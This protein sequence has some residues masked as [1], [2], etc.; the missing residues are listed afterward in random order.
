[1][2][3]ELV[4]MIDAKIASGTLAT[5]ATA[6]TGWLD[7]AAPIVTMVVTIVVGTLTAWYTWERAIKL[8]RERENE[9]K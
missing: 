9:D 5:V 6:T 7:I 4:H 8:K 2:N 3:R 1:M